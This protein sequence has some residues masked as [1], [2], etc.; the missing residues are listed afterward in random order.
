MHIHRDDLM[1]GGTKRRGLRLLLE[2][3]PQSTVFYAGTTMGH[4]ALALAHACADAG[5]Q[6]HI[7]ISGDDT[8]DMVQKLKASK[9]IV[10]LHAPMP[11]MHLYACAVEYARGETVFPPG[12]AMPE[13]ETA[14]ADALR[15]IDVTAYSEIWTCCVTGTLTRAFQTAF[16]AMPFKTVRVVKQACDAGNAD[17]FIAP[18]KYH[19]AAITPPPYPSCPYTDAKVWQFARAHAAPDALIWNTAG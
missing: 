5:K 16:P 6:A 17:I 15:Q 10:H 8:N 13:F 1:E 12:F 2:T 14:M 3:I 7:F 9:A 19:Q 18:E 11:V 4:G